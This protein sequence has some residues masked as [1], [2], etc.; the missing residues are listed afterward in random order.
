[1]SAIYQGAMGPGR[2]VEDLFIAAT[3]MGISVVLSARIAGVDL[4]SYG[5]KQ[6]LAGSV[7]DF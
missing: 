1:M 5:R 4:L 3:T 7:N 6:R 2:P